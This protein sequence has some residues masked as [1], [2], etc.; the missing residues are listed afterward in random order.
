MLHKQYCD[1]ICKDDGK[2]PAALRG[3]P[4]FAGVDEA[5]RGALAGPVVAAAVILD[6][7]RPIAGLQDSKTLSPRRRT[8]LAFAIKRHAA[9]WAVAKSE[10]LEIDMLNILGASLLAMKR[11]VAALCLRPQWVAV[12][13]VHCPCLPF[14]SVALVRGDQRVAAISAASILAKTVRD[15]EMLRLD[16]Q[17]PQYGLASHKGYPVAAHLEALRCYGA[18]PVHRRRFAPVAKVLR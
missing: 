9:S 3:D 6:A 13:G 10:V 5:G 17:Y 8:A 11:A 12:D 4:L 1:Y 2:L 18:T 15:R 7:A 14:R 16:A